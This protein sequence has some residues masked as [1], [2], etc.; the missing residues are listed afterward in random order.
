[1]VEPVPVAPAPATVRETHD[2]AAYRAAVCDSFVPLAVS[3]ERP[4]AFWSRVRST[5]AG[6]VLLSEIAATPHAVHRTP[7]LIG[8]GGRRYYK[9][10]LQ[11]AGTSML[12][13]DDREATLRPGEMALYDSH[14]PYT[15]VH[16]S[17]FRSIVLMV[18]Q[19]ALGLP[20]EAVA[21]LTAVRL[22]G[23]VGAVAAP[24]LADVAARLDE[25]PAVA[26]ARLL[27]HAVDLVATACAS[28]LDAAPHPHAALAA[29][30]R[31][32]VED[33]LGE[34]DL[35][36]ASIAAAHYVS[37]RHL[38][39][40]FHEQGT[41]VSGW[42][43]ER[44]LE[45]ARRDLLDPLQSERPVAVIAARWGFADPAHFSRVFRAAHGTSPSR[46]RAEGPGPG[47]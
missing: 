18:E 21:Q 46:L 25:V 40:V 44:R 24:F 31:A 8:T 14:R 17:S 11:L 1:M 34:A 29:Q 2:V 4:G 27:H 42:V 35:G 5:T 13:Q 22:D 36:P 9:L 7:A 37:T 41:T 47:G 19:Q 32:Y 3:V 15:L 45:R 28:V 6:G 16:G 39:G 23:P 26:A 20:R 38:Q 10:S 43:R 12:V 33:H 30:V